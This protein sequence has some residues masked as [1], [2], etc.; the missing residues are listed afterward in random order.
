MKRRNLLLASL[1]A[2]IVFAVLVISALPL[3]V[4]PEAISQRIHA[5]AEL[6]TGRKVFFRDTPRVTWRP[7]L[8]VEISNLVLEDAH[9][10]PED[11]PLVQIEK[12][13][14]RLSPLAALTGS[15]EIERFQFVRPKFNLVAR[16]EGKASWA[17]PRGGVSHLLGKARQLRAETPAGEKPDFSKIG[18]VPLGY[19]QILDGTVQYKNSRT[20]RR[21]TITNLN[22]E[23][24]WPNTAM[25]ASVNGNAIWREESVEFRLT[26]PQM[27]PLLAGGSSPLTISSSS[28]AFKLDFNGRANTL[29][30]VQ[31]NGN[32]RLSSPSLRRLAGFL[33]QGTAN[34]TTLADFA[35]SAEM[36]ATRSQIKLLNAAVTLDGNSAKGALQITQFDRAKPLIAGTLAYGTLSFDSYGEAIRQEVA[37]ASEG[38]SL[39]GLIDAVELDLRVSANTATLAGLSATEFAASITARNGEGLLDIGNGRLHDGTLVGTARLTRKDG[40]AAATMK[41]RLSGFTLPG[42]FKPASEDEVSLT[43]KSNLEVDLSA[44]GTSANELASN[45]KGML[46]L[47]AENGTLTGIDLSALRDASTGEEAGNAPMELSG[48]TAFSKLEG[49]FSL[50]RDMAW[51]QRMSLVSP[52]LSAIARGSIDLGNGGIAIR[53]RLGPGGTG[54]ATTQ[55]SGPTAASADFVVGGSLSAPIANQDT[56][57]G[58]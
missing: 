27:L 41:G 1:S 54:T 43:G 9:G 17:F 37:L 20:G 53:L 35:L 56:R 18:T 5:Q 40:R 24:D 57:P 51:M 38:V 10:R 55:N 39:L 32:L 47:E 30:D 11:S 8:G 15:V 46:R 50:Y 22:L 42:F 49:T 29:A 4:S 13:R 23:L 58:R 26:V 3:L 28:A 33:G 31:L 6:I 14:A 19:L 44:S 34:G 36:D 16:D 2:I 12:L 21:E 25:A 52:T 7:F 48:R 45:P